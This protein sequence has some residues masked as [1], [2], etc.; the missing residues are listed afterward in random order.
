MILPFNTEKEA[1]ERN[2][3][4]AVKRGC[5]MVTTKYWW[6]DPIEYE[7]KWYLDVGD[8]EGLT[9]DELEMCVEKLE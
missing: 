7:S 8:G 3:L 1:K 4:E 6:S 9:Q 5:D 2:M